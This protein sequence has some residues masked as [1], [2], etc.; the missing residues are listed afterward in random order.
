MPRYADPEMHQCRVVPLPSLIPSQSSCLL[1]IHL[2][3]RLYPRSP[4][5]RLKRRLPT[6]QLGSANLP[7]LPG[8]PSFKL[9]THANRLVA[10]E[11]L[12]HV[13]H[14]ALALAKAALELLTLGG[15]GLEEGRREAFE[16][17]VAGDEDAVRILQTLG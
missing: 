9:M 11:S 7:F 15:E 14:A 13:N 10:A 8:A 1:W 17:R 2:T 16:G 5:H 12:A 4:L 3:L 6:I